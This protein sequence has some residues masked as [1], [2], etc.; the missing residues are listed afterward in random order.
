[1]GKLQLRPTADQMFVISYLPGN[2][3]ENFDFSTALELSRQQEKERDFEGACNTRFQAFQKLVELVPDDVPVELEWEDDNSQAALVVGYC[4]AIDHFLIGDWE[5]AAAILE[6]ILELDPEDHLE[7][8][9]KL[10]YTYLA[11][12]EYESFDEVIN[13]VNDKYIDKVI[14]TLWSEFR[15]KGEFPEGELIRMKRKFAPY[16]K[17]FTADEHPVDEHYLKDIESEKPSQEALARELWLQTEHLWQL[18]PGFIEGLRNHAL[19]LEQKD[20]EANNR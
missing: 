2:E 7:A 13:D 9:V 6:M 4:S 3:E 5:M 10:A 19:I 11:M 16:F 17:E 8:T 20:K 1:M 15:R 18:F 14:L 12:E